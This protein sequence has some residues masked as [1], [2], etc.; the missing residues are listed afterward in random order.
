MLSTLY[1]AVTSKGGVG[2]IEWHKTVAWSP[3]INSILSSV[4]HHL[5]TRPTIT[6]S[7]GPLAT[8]L[9]P[10]ERGVGH[11]RQN[12]SHT[13]LKEQTEGALSKALSVAVLMGPSQ[14]LT[15]CSLFEPK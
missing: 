14:T 12:T 4:R 9:C 13:V 8:L 2:S 10:E 6:S 7:N 11:T 3:Q 15:A 5:G 1:G